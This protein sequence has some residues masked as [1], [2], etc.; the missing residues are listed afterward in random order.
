MYFHQNTFNRLYSGSDVSFLSASRK[1]CSLH[2]NPSMGTMYEG[3]YNY[4]IRSWLTL[5]LSCGYSFV[6][7]YE[8]GSNMNRPIPCK[9]LWTKNHITTTISTAFFPSCDVFQVS[10]IKFNENFYIDFQMLFRCFG[11]ILIDKTMWF[12]V[13]LCSHRSSIH[14]NS[15]A[16]T[17]R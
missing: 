3:S 4:D 1:L 12:E 17:T 10:R 2:C 11:V 8:T 6:P 16:N 7:P 14:Q 9:A 13:I 15:I 5:C